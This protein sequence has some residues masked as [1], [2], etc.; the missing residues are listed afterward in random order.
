[1]K[2]QIK[3]IPTSFQPGKKRFMF[4]LNYYRNAHYHTLSDAKVYMA[5]WIKL[6]QI[7]EKFTE[8][9]KIEYSIWCQGNADFMNYATVVDK[10][11]QDAIVKAG[12]LPDDNVNYVK[13]CHIQFEGKGKLRV[14]AIISEIKKEEME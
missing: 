6:L 9:V 11:F 3:D 14:D 1:M 13:C 2:I 4:N 12:L 7:K 8:P 10:F 5:Q